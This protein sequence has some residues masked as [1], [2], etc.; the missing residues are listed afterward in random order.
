MADFDSEDEREENSRE[1]GRE[2]TDTGFGVRLGRGIDP[3]TDLLR[4]E[5]DSG[6]TP[7]VEEATASESTEVT[8]AA[9]G[10]Y[11]LNVDRGEEEIIVTADLPGVN[12]AEIAVGIGNETNDLLIQVSGETIG[13][14]SLP[15]KAAVATSVTYNN[16]ILEIRL[17]PAFDE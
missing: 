6:S 7:P 2:Q 10:E 4:I 15:W 16:Y 13:R 3:L 9:D 1:P 17:S 8:D 5:G 14:L 11:L 12:E